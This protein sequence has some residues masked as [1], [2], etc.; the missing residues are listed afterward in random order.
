MRYHLS[1]FKKN[2]CELMRCNPDYTKD[3]HTFSTTIDK[4]EIL[5]KSNHL[6]HITS[7]SIKTQLSSGLFASDNMKK[8]QLATHLKSY[9]MAIA[10]LI[11]LDSYELQS[12][13][14][15]M[16]RTIPYTG[17]GVVSNQY[18]IENGWEVT[19]TIPISEFETRLYDYNNTI[20]I[21]KNIPPVE[22]FDE[23]FSALSF[24]FNLNRN[25][26]ILEPNHLKI[27]EVN[28]GEIEKTPIMFAQFSNDTIIFLQLES[29]YKHFT[30]INLIKT[31][32]ESIGAFTY[33]ETA[34]LL[35]FIPNRVNA[36]S[37]L[38]NNFLSNEINVPIMIKNITKNIKIIQLF[39]PEKYIFEI[40]GNR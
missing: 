21:I 31:N 19:I 17:K 22:T 15:N 24:I 16:L 6:D 27:T 4:T 2:F 34:A 7:I 35:C 18:R 40:Y 39:N 12:I 13:T 8:N 23:M 37:L 5:A 30:G 9:V 1:D 38:L 20:H 3:F 32:D 29:D 14:T 25:L 33:K 36:A 10:T 26:Q 28:L 11:N